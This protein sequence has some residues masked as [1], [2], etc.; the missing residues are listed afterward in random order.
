MIELDWQRA[1]P[2]INSF[3]E[4][5]QKTSPPRLL[6]RWC[7]VQ[8]LSLAA[9]TRMTESTPLT[10]VPGTHASHRPSL[11]S[12]AYK[13]LWRDWRAGELRLLVLAVVL[14][15]AALTS[16]A[17]FVD[18]LDRGMNRDA[19]QLLGGDGMVLSDKPLPADF[20]AQAL[21]R[22]L[23]IA[24]M[25]SF[26]SMARAPDAQGGAAKLVAVKA[27]SPAYPLR[28]SLEIDAGSATEPRTL[29]RGPERGTVW[30]EDRVLDALNL[31]V[32]DTLL[33]G[34]SSLRVAGRLLREPDRAPGFMM[35]APR[36]MMAE[37][38]LDATG[39]IQPASRVTWRL[40]IAAAQPN[41]VQQQAEVQSYLDWATAQIESRKLHGTRVESLQNG[42]PETQQTMQRAKS[43]L[44]L[45]ALL[46]ALLAAIAVGLAARDFAQRRL[47]TCALL[48]V[49][50]EPQQR[51]AGSFA[52]GLMS[53]GVLASIV[54]VLC[55]LVLH[56]FFV[57][58][59]GS[60]LRTQLPPPGMWPAGFGIAAGVTLC[61]GFGLPSILQLGRV[62]ALRVMRR[63][64]GEPRGLSLGVALGALASFGALLWVVADNAVLG[65]WAL[66]GFAGA[67]ALFALAAWLALAVLRR[68]LH[69]RWAQAWPTWLR[70]A[71][72]QAAS[73]PGLALMQVTSL[74]LGLFALILLV[75]LRTDLVSSWRNATPADAPNR[76]VINVQ[77]DQAEAFQQALRS[78]GVTRFDWYPMTRGRLTGINGKAIRTQDYTEDRARRLLEREFNLSHAGQSPQHNPIVQGRWQ[79]EEL[80]A[81]SVEE[82]LMKTLGL[83]LGDRLRFEVAGQELSGRITSVRKVDWT[84][85]RVNFFVMFPR[86]SM[87]E[88]PLTYIAGFRAP[89]ANGE[90]ASNGE[91]ATSFDNRLTRDFP[92]ITL[93][94]LTMSINEAQR[95][96]GQVTHA[97]EFL[98]VFTLLAGSIVLVAALVASREQRAREFGVMRALG[99]GNRLLARV[100]AVELLGTGALAGALA[101]ISA[102]ALSA[103]LAYRVFDFEWSIPL[104][105]PLL[106]ATLGALIALSVGWWGLREVLARP[107]TQTLRQAQD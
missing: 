5:V 37:A 39:L 69:S 56:E 20:E 102:L 98:F 18:R 104:W 96:L 86:A 92:N 45:V 59:L 62:P 107:V 22:K 3:A 16:V 2:G 75:L 71:T 24:R 73:R 15:V 66:G 21:A 19:A 6:H 63:E 58:V 97:V 38:D 101:A 4:I 27:V 50:G 41:S 36:L 7:K 74:G 32:G 49:L 17:F 60:L 13:Q 53:A 25:A 12:W 100:Q 95:I 35:F 14:A 106:G 26:V 28:G 81:V 88:L 52:I 10:A 80:D 68:L 103:V 34:D 51:I 65:A 78:A 48:R 87:P 67:A 33:L 91:R 85:M 11:L 79:A 83:K 70:L 9:S 93:V 42:R 1:A 30:A 64:L 23:H 46:T 55:G 72:R 29:D 76:F 43:F 90:V 61:A 77:A 47:D 8:A 82:G 31:K 44:K 57:W 94:D 54:G 105:W 84:S 99:A 89:L 40:A